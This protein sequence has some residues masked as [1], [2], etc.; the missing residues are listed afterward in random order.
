MIQ[1][2]EEG[3]KTNNKSEQSHRNLFENINRL[4]VPVIRVSKGGEWKDQK[5]YLK[6]QYL[7]Y[8][9]EMDKSFEI[10]KTIFTKDEIENLISALSIKDIEELI[11]D[12]YKY[13]YLK[14]VFHHQTPGPR[15]LH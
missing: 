7:K 1:T 10:H 9:D 13:M 14:R 12:S 2:E 6:K 8:Y 4:K 11:F 5:K 15:Q 3:E